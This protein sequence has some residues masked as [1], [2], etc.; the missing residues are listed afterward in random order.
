MY[1]K[2]CLK[3]ILRKVGYKLSKYA[4]SDIDQDKDFIE[5]YEKCKKY[6]KVSR[7][8]C[9]GL[10]NA[11]NYIV[12][13]NIEGDMVECGAWKGGSAMIIAL[14]LLKLNDMSRI[15]WLYDT[16]EGMS[17][18]TEN[19]ISS[20]NRI[21]AGKEWDKNNKKD[22]N[23]WCYSSLEEVTGNMSLTG[24]PLEKIKFIKGKVEDT[25]PKNTPDNIS[26]LRLDTDWYEST[27]HELI[28]LYPR[29]QTGGVLII[30]DY[31]SWLGARK[32][33][34]EYCDQKEVK[35]LLNKMHNGRIGVKI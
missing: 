11:V 32:A 15:I 23:F 22:D 33:V 21:N 5:I 17:K 19:D 20:D 14:T 8:R 7:E 26:I 16:Y 1:L 28:H 29:I 24:Y 12:K 2:E 34:K 25:I 27:K 30:D 18:P 13:K 9:Y 3:K 4:E 6:T 10:Y 35:I 31:G